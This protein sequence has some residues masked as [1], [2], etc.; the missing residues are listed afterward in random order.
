M[1][2]KTISTN[3]SIYHRTEAIWITCLYPMLFKEHR[4]TLYRC[5]HQ[6]IILPM[7]MIFRRLGAFFIRRRI[8][9]NFLYLQCLK[10]YLRWLIAFPLSIELFIEGGRS[11]DGKIR[12]PQ[13]GILQLIFESF[14]SRA[15]KLYK[16]VPISINYDFTPEVSSYT[17]EQ[18]GKEKKKESLFSFTVLHTFRE[19]SRMP[20]SFFRPD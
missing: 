14:G 4:P 7:G 1:H 11:R 15:S 9:G 13:T 3:T 19:V 10:T 8:S 12:K 5:R 18:H 17:Q 16:I 20:Y 2:L 6:L